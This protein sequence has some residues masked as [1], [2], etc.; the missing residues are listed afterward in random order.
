V[1]ELDHLLELLEAKGWHLYRGIPHTPL[2]SVISAGR[3][4]SI[5]RGIYYHLMPATTHDADVDEVRDAVAHAIQ[6]NSM[7]TYDDGVNKGR[8]DAIYVSD[9]D[10]AF[11]TKPDS[12]TFSLSSL[13]VIENA[14]K[15]NLSNY[16][17]FFFESIDAIGSFLSQKQIAPQL[18]PV[19]PSQLRW[20]YVHRDEDPTWTSI[21]PENPGNVLFRGQGKRYMPCV[22]T[23]SRG[24]G[25]DVRFFHELTN[26][27]QARLI[28]NLA[29]TE[30]FVTL[31][32]NTPPAQ[33]LN[34]RRIYLD[35]MAVAQ[36][37]GLPTGF[38]DLTQSFEVA[39]FFAC[40]RFDPAH[41]SWFPVG[42]GE[43]VIYCV[44]WRT[45]PIEIIS[46]INLQAFPRPSE[47]WG[48]TCELRLGDDFDRLPFVTK[49]IFKQ[50]LERSQRIL[51]KFS[52]G[53]DL[54]P[55]DPLSDLADRILESLVLPADIVT[56]I[57]KDLVE[58][59]QGKPQSTAEEI[60]D[61]LHEFGGITVS[62]EVRILDL[63]RINAE[64][65]DT[66]SRR[67]DSFFN[68]ISFRLVRRRK[69]SSDGE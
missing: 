34:Q 9:S 4:R 26:P 10:F 36:H 2:P 48:W 66:W 59:P 32:R 39:S 69:D 40:C 20:T 65:E 46:P 17:T 57:A 51:K 22:P 31:L 21:Y 37:Y 19:L 18:P 1:A 7:P 42:D 60:F 14:L 28:A 5:D 41:N 6:T 12:F 52:H 24:L 25:A 50:D 27:N 56:R 62:S 49:L 63:E 30:W 55:D 15:F 61:L 13:S 44:D 11:V 68:G 67:R 38:I 64:L 29:R 35:E 53:R 43:G 23:A 54:F 45:A 8:I 16:N 47:Q 3:A 33:W 58:D